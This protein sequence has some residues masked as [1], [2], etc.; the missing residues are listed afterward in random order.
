MLLLLIIIPLSFSAY[1]LKDISISISIEKDGTLKVVETYSII[2]QGELDIG[3]YNVNL[4]NSS[5][6][7]WKEITN[8]SEIYVHFNPLYG[9][10]T[11]FNFYPLPLKSYNPLKHT[12]VGGLTMEYTIIPLS[13]ER[14]VLKKNALKPRTYLWTLNIDAFSFPTT[15]A[16]DPYLDEKT[17]FTI[18]LP[19]GAKI[20]EVHPPPLEEKGGKLSWRDI[21]LANFELKFKT[22][23]SVYDEIN[24]FLSEKLNAL[25]SFLI[26]DKGKFFILLSF[27]TFIG[28]GLYKGKISQ[29]G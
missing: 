16:G 20:I 6:R 22:E 7:K 29:M 1:S 11:D 5:L 3:K 17:T 14:T 15:A 4:K 23:E 13:G 19:E 8:I 24:R 28:F 27:L 10:I 26:S 25:Y 2:V 12:A 9:K 21:I 18:T